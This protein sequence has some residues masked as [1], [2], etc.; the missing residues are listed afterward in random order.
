[1]WVYQKN[2]IK[3]PLMSLGRLRRNLEFFRWSGITI[4]IITMKYAI[5]L[6]SNGQLVEIFVPYDEEK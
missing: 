5:I 6:K 1:M 4:N 3:I 2:P